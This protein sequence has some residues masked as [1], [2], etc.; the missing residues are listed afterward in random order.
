M[1]YCLE[2]KAEHLKIAEVLSQKTGLPVVATKYRGKADYF[3]HFIKLYNAGPCDFISLIDHA[4]MVLTSSFHGTAF[5]LLFQKPFYVVDGVSDGRICG[6][7]SMSGTTGNN[8]VSGIQ[9]INKKPLAA[10]DSLFLDRERTRSRQYLIDALGL[11][12][13]G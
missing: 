3:N 11:Y 10:G 13:G 8:L 1:F 6:L 2:P 9:E 4:A 5:S 7:L 12:D